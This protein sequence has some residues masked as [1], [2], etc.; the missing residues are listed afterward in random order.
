METK[1]RSENKVKDYPAKSS[2]VLQNQDTSQANAK[3]G[4]STSKSG[5]STLSAEQMHL[6][7]TEALNGTKDSKKQWIL[8]P[9]HHKN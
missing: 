6:G 3:Q 2:K 8:P 9:F 4:A 5:S 7:I 1:T